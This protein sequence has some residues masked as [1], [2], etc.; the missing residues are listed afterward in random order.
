MS[1][2]ES[3]PDYSFVFKS[4]DSFSRI[5]KASQLPELQDLIRKANDRYF[6]WTDLAHRIPANIEAK[7]EEVWAYLKMTRSANMRNTPIMDKK[8]NYFTYWI[9]DCLHRGISEVDKWSGGQ[10]I[11][12]Q[13]FGLPSKE[14]YI[15]NSLMDEAIASSQLEGASTEYEVAKNMLRSGRKPKD[16]NEQMIVNNWNAMQFIRENKKKPF[17]MDRLFELHTILTLDTLES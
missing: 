17:S 4:P 1:I 13:P 11:T 14:R 6:Y 15:I 16:K 8:G 3:P 2:I 7:P 5:L 9:P 12:D 10:I